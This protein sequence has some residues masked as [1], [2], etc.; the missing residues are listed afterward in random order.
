MSHTHT[1]ILILPSDAAESWQ[2]QLGFQDAATPMM[3]GMIDLHHDFFF[4]FL[5][6]I[7]VFVSW[8]MLY[9]IFTTQKIQSEKLK[10]LEILELCD[11]EKV[12]E[13]KIS[14]WKRSIPHPKGLRK[15]NMVAPVQL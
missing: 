14:L 7:L 11:L 3:Q 15:L 13:V 9:G 6:L 5:V 1:P 2:W 8:F 12:I 4:V 10:F